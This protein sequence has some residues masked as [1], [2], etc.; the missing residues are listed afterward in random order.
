MPPRK[1]RPNDFD[2]LIDRIHLAALVA[3]MKPESVCQLVFKD[4]NVMR[5]LQRAKAR[6]IMRR[7]ALEHFIASRG[8]IAER[9]DGDAE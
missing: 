2:S 9:G 6:M 7:A 8:G 4:R 5:R 1:A 3:G